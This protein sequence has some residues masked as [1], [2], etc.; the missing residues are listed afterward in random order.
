MPQVIP[1][2][3]SAAAW[4]V[5]TVGIQIGMTAY[6]KS[7]MPEPPGQVRSMTQSRPARRICMGLPS[8]ATGAYLE[9][10]Q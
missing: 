8:R 4:T 3:A 1:M 9:A 2:A 10:S 6:A 7:Q 5:A